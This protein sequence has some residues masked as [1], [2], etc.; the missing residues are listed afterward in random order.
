MMMMMMM[1]MM[2]RPRKLKDG[3]MKPIKRVTREPI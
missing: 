3:R 1:V 2:K